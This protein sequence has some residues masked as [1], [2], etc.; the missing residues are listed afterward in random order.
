MFSTLVH[1]IGH[2]LG[3]YHP[4]ETADDRTAFATGVANMT[5]SIMT[6]IPTGFVNPIDGTQTAPQFPLVFDQ[7][8]IQEAYGANLGT[9]T[10][11]TTYR[12]EPGT[13][14]DR[15][16]VGDT[17]TYQGIPFGII[18]DGAGNDTIDASSIGTASFIDLRP[19][20]FSAIGSHDANLGA[21]ER[22]RNIAVAYR[23]DGLPDTAGWIENAK[24]GAGSDLLIGNARENQLEGNAGNDILDGGVAANAG[25]GTIPVGQGD[26]AADTLVG[27]AGNDSFIL[28]E[29]G[30]VDLNTDL[31][32]DDGPSDSVRFQDKQDAMLP[33]EGWVER[34]V[35]AGPWVRGRWQYELSGADLV[36][37]DTTT[38]AQ[39]KLLNF[40]DGDYSIRLFQPLTR[41]YADITNVII[42]EPGAHNLSGTAAAD[43][44][45]LLDG[46]DTANA[47]AG[48]D[49]VEGGDGADNINGDADNDRLYGEA[50]RDEIDGGSGND[51]AYGGLDPDI[52]QGRAG[53]DKLA[54]QAGAD[55]VTGDEGDDEVYAGDPVALATALSLAE[56]QAASGLK[57]EWLDG[58]EGNDIVVAEADNDQLMGGGGADIMVGGAGDDN[59]VGDMERTL[60]NI[61]T[62]AVTREIIQGNPVL[63]QLTY[64]AEA[65]VAVSPNGAGDKL[66]GGAGADWIFAG[67]GSDYVEGGTGD[68]VAFGEAGDDVL[69]GGIGNDVLVG[70]NPGVVAVA[71]EG[72]DYLDGGDGDDNL[73][74]NGGADVLI[75]GRGNDTLS[76]GAGRDT[77]VFN[78]GDGTETIFDT[79]ANSAGPD[80]SVLILG[81]GVSRGDIKFRVG[82]LAV[83][84]GPGNPADPNSPRDVIHFEGFDQGNP[85]ATT[86]LGEIRFADG[87][88]MSY[89][90]MLAQGFDIDGTEGNDNGQAGEPPMLVGTGVVDRVRGFG[91]NDVLAGLGGDDFLDG[92]AGDDELQG[93]DSND[94]LDGGTEDDVLFGDAGDD[95]AS[96]G[97]GNDQIVG[98]GGVDILNGGDGDDQLFGDDDTVAGAEHGADLIS[99]G[100][101]NDTIRGHGGDDQIFGDEGGDTLWGEAGADYLE[102]GA[103]NDF[104]F[105][106]ADATPLA[107]QGN[108]TLIGGDGDD[109]LVGH[110]GNDALDGGSGIDVLFGNAGDDMLAGGEGND[111]LQGHDGADTLAGGTG[112]D[113][114]F[115]DAGDDLYLFNLGDGQDLVFDDSAISADVLRFGTGIVASDMTLARAG[116]NLVVMHANGTDQA[117][118]A[119]W[120]ISSG[121][122]LARFEFADGTVWTGSFA[123]NEA[124]KILRG[125]SGNDQ[126][127]GSSIAETYYGLEGD[128][129]LIGN[130]GADTFIG[131]AGSDTLIGGAGADVFRFAVGDGADHIQESGFTD[132]KLFFGPTVASADISYARINNNLVMSHANGTDSVTVD[133]WFADASSFKLQSVTFENDGT[134]LSTL[135]LQTQATVIPHQYTL[136][137]GDGAKL[138]EDWGGQ[139]TLT[140]GPGIAD[141]DITTSRVGVD[142]LLTHIN[143]LDRVTV[144]GWFDSTAKQIEQISFTDSGTVLTSAEVTEPFLTLTGTAANDLIEGGNA[145]GETING[146]AGNDQIYGLGGDDQ[147]TGGFGDDTIY[148]G[149]GNDRYYFSAGD[150]SD[151]VT[152]VDPGANVVQFGPG[153]ADKSNVSSING[154]R[155]VTFTG[156]TDSVRL[157]TTGFAQLDI[158]FELNGTS[159]ANTLTGSAFGDVIQ[160]LE[161]NDAVYGANGVDEIYGGAGNDTLEGGADADILYGGD[162]DDVLDGGRLN[163]AQS[164]EGYVGVFYGGPGNDTLWGNENTDTYFFNLGDGRDTIIDEPYVEGITHFFSGDDELSFGPGIAA[165]TINVRASGSDLVVDVTPQESVTLRNWMSSSSYRVDWFRFSD[166]TRLGQ[167]Q[168][169]GLL[170]VRQ[171]TDGD[172]TLVGTDSAAETLYGKAGNDTLSGLGGNDTLDGGTGNDTLNGGLGNDQLI[173]GAGTDV[174]DGGAG[175]DTYYFGPGAGQDRISETSGVDTVRFDSGVTASNITLGRDVNSLVLTL[176]GTAD[177]LTITDYFVSSAFRIENFVFSDGSQL[178][179]EAA[180]LDQFLNVRGTAA[181]DVLTGSAGFD[182]MYGF[183]GNDTLNALAD[184]D[185][186][187]GGPDNDTLNGGTGN[188]NLQGEAGND[189][190][191][192]AVGDGQDVVVD[193]SGFDAIAFGTGISTSAV[194]TARSGSAL[195]LNV[196]VSGN[197]GS[198]TV[199]NY[200]NGQEAEEVRFADGTVWDVATVRAKVLAAAQ[201]AG[202]DLITGYETSDTINS[203]AGNDTVYGGGGNDT[204]DGGTGSDH[205]YGEA[206]DDILIAGTGDPNNA[207]V[208]NFV[209]GGFGNDVLVASGKTDSLY[210]E[211]G[212]DIYVGSSSVS[213]MQDVGGNN[214]FD[215]QAGNDQLRGGDQNDLV[216]GGTGDDVTDGDLDANGVRGQ[217]VLAFNKSDGK[218]SVS[219]LGGGSTISI[220][221]GTTY[222]N[223][224]LEKV[225]TT[226]RLKTSNSHYISLTDWYGS[227]ANQAVSTLQIVIEGTSNYNASSSNPMNNRKIQA[228]DFLGLVAAFDAAGQ[229]SNFSVANNLANYRLWGSDTDAIGGAVAY[230]YARTGSISSLTYDQM[231]AVISAPEFGV[232]AQ[233][234]STSG[235]MSA[236]AEAQETTTLSTMQIVEAGARETAQDTS[237]DGSHAEDAFTPDTSADTRTANQTGSELLA[238]P[239]TSNVPAMPEVARGLT[240]HG[241]QV[242]SST[243]AQAQQIG[244]NDAPADVDLPDTGHGSGIQAERSG[245]AVRRAGGSSAESHPFKEDGSDDIAALVSDRLSHAPQFHFEALADFFEAEANKKNTGLT[246]EQIAANWARVRAYTNALG[247]S[248]SADDFGGSGPFGFGYGSV[249][250]G[251]DGESWSLPVRRAVGL[252]DT[253]AANLKQLEGVSGAMRVLG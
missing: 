26:G 37:T 175:D 223:L 4:D 228:F 65:Q 151:T 64:N 98:G 206:G 184:N 73:Q 193:T 41:Q 105:G 67:A 247:A 217:D 210:G 68:D 249:G 48:D 11:N 121:Y 202:N 95:V 82:S 173:G 99:G 245:D 23:K 226:L 55:V 84:L 243:A 188:D 35:T 153:L 207:S 74:G 108:D 225:G 136:M 139:D 28:R 94:V 203:L 142:L 22:G 186:L 140:L 126:I 168:I 144:K 117:S 146:L 3:L 131:G 97:A 18:W 101:G 181:D 251:L 111:E 238:A 237:V 147:I 220:G 57:G 197:T 103:D 33:F 159:A 204:I 222:S 171:G 145:Y 246:S 12:F 209:Y 29:G 76:G 8:G 174:L 122:Q 51:E 192:Y 221:G 198:V 20:H 233:P 60:V 125:T 214:L 83:D 156:S 141:S 201:T 172:D 253:A 109:Q 21:T 32:D 123:G 87:T 137:V 114:L 17:V 116:G 43:E 102:G 93:G 63:Y 154:G 208:S 180:I 196:N 191:V 163:N 232:S 235:M 162:G 138:I 96:G 119:N 80:A 25:T 49:L 19:G 148:G 157:L 239:D 218:D 213:T 132:D 194:S 135:Q 127:V 88:S 200:F 66:Y 81:D 124:L 169:L 161:G 155:L 150:G 89:G 2:A 134:V 182:V 118:V 39:G 205:L 178:P 158:K 92:G 59:L 236:S 190:Y 231:R 10:G 16:V 149:T 52:V 46:D 13:T 212:N 227:P 106:D 152:E 199:Q 79:D 110:G 34:D 189:T 61:D 44:I 165:D 53:A 71:D 187:Y 72:G 219:R 160:A 85:T 15:T 216:I 113:T 24:G 112:N 248:A 30:G 1:E 31:V 250:G 42:D 75:G 7:A 50:G 195:V 242:S 115:G 224:S 133:N 183:E 129:Q 45:Q 177:S 128:D 244:S 6:G 38:N 9:R 185:T 5:N 91:G 58:G 234:I 179:S 176:D 215:A 78:R 167:S 240:V 229:P 230:Q 252:N 27:G 107:E 241:R 36:V 104:L 170:N 211:A 100:L 77:Y 40:A 164:D 86:P 120:Y 62:W 56:T 130:D 47:G 143:G 54:G 70:D 90:E 166:G 69:I 14:I